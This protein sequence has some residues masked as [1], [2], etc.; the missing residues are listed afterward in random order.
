MSLS[1]W[2]TMKQI[3]DQHSLDR[4]APESRI[5]WPV[6]PEPLPGRDRRRDVKFHC[7]Y[8]EAEVDRNDCDL[9]DQKKDCAKDGYLNEI[10]KK[11]GFSFGLA[12]LVPSQEF[13]QVME[14]LKGWGINVDLVLKIIE[15]NVRELEKDKIAVI[16]ER[17]DRSYMQQKRQ[18]K[19][20]K[21]RRIYI[22]PRKI[23]KKV[24]AER[25]L[26]RLTHYTFVNDIICHI[27]G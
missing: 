1:R 7:K 19:E 5:S 18:V 17:M 16:E 21:T 27:V 12:K 26:L 14:N 23:E 3:N 11:Y 6:S 2:V 9:C 22:R 15:D 25:S 20:G 4:V 10:D 13:D 8:I 24:E